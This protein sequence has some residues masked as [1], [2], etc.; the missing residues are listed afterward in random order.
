MD[1][2]AVVIAGNQFTLPVPFLAGMVL[3]EGQAKALNQTYHENIRNNWAA[4][5]KELGDAPASDALSEMQKKITEY[6]NEYEFPVAGT[7]RAPVDPVEREAN[8]I[9]KSFVK[10]KL[11]EKGYTFKKGPEDMDA[12]AWAERVN[13]NIEKVAADERILKMAKKRV[14]E[15]KKG[16]AALAADLD[17]G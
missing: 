7:P 1:T 2:K 12:E 9:A 16:I 13:A 17:V 14:E 5:V 11:A 3:T 6:A 8:A 4:K 10:D 15:K